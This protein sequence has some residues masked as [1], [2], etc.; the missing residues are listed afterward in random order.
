[1]KITTTRMKLS[2]DLLFNV[3]TYINP[4]HQRELLLRGHK[5]PVI[6]NLG[7]TKDLNE[8]IDLTDNDI[9][10][11]G[12]F[13][14]LLKLK[15]LLISKN[16][17]SHIQSDLSEALPNIENLVLSSN[18]LSQLS[19]ID[20]LSGFTK[21]THLSLIDN[22]VVN[23]DYY[24]LYVVWRNPSIRV[25]DFVKVKDAERSRA[26]EL[27]GPSMDKPT[28]LATQIMGSKS[29]TIQ[30]TGEK[31]ASRQLTEEEKEDIRQKLK[32]ATSLEEVEKLHQVLRTGVLS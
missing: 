4:M 19:D 30:S 22:P 20:P 21:L 3:P 13:P 27:F 15:T 32:V 31:Q 5:I 8:S 6:E 24:R 28:S 10:V 26:K 2:P 17:I 16:R 12:N 25:L 11:L 14:R 1:M 7:V 18:Q 9:R 29:K 23:L